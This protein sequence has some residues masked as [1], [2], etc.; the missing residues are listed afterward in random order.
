MALK[1]VSDLE[2][3][4]YDVIKDNLEKYYDKNKNTVPDSLIEVSET[5]NEDSSFFKSYAY[6]LN[7]LSCIFTDQLFHKDIHLDGDKIFDDDVIIRGSLSVVSNHTHNNNDIVFEKSK[8]SLKSSNNTNIEAATS[9]S[10]SA[11]TTNLSTTKQTNISSG[12]GISLSSDNSK[13]DIQ[14]SKIEIKSNE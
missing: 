13:I 8:I 7:S 14:K 10:V 12:S 11:Q 5:Q 3:R 9:L 4:E 6:D 1:R 2:K